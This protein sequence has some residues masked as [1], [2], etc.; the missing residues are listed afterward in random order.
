MDD[1]QIEEFC[2]INR[3]LR[4][5]VT[6]SGNL[7]IR[8]PAFGRDGNR[9]AK[10]IGR[11][12]NWNDLNGTGVGFDSS[13]LFVLP[14]GTRRSPDGSWIRKTRLATLTVGQE[15]KFLPLCPDFVIELRTASDGLNEL[16]AKMREYV[17]NGAQ[18]GW[19]LDP[20]TR[21]VY[22]YRADGTVEQLNEAESI[23]GD[24]LLPGFVLNLRQ[25][26]AADF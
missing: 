17:A 7:T 18:L 21:R 4:I 1:E 11:I 9:K 5:E 10:L 12:G 13:T 23:T 8:P 16:Q 26:W 14:K 2:R 24:P 22:V 19:L 20:S 6:A 15:D 3:D 25:I